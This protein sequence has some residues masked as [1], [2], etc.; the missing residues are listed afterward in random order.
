MEV[1]CGVVIELGDDSQEVKTRHKIRRNAEGNKK[2]Q[3]Y[4]LIFLI[5]F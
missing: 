1:C 3:I 4:F 2:N 5:Y